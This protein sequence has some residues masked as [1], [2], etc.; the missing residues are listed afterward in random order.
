VAGWAGTS[1]SRKQWAELIAEEAHQLGY[2]LTPRQLAEAL[3][4]RE[5]EGFSEEGE[6]IGPW[7]E[8]K[9]FGST[10]ARLNYKTSTRA[11]LERWAG[12]GKSWWP[13]WGDWEK[14]ETE[15]PGPSRYKRHLALATAVLAKRGVSS[16]RAP[17]IKASTAKHP[18]E[19]APPSPGSFGEDLMHFGLVAL[20]VLGGVVMIGMG[21]TRLLRQGRS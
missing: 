18:P 21:T 19:N 6:H 20:L 14:P 3:G 2:K 10:A 8:E 11:A 7:E 15:G 13:G 12:D 5:A 1:L 4:V 17:K 16:A 9:S